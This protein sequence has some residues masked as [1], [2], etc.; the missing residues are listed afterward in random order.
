MR[1]NGKIAPTF[2]YTVLTGQREGVVV[3]MTRTDVEAVE[4]VSVTCGELVESM[5]FTCAS[6]RSRAL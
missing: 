3:E 6:A 1:L 4:N 5:L 2:G